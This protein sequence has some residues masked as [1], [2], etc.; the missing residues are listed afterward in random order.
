MRAVV[1]V[2]VGVVLVVVVES[3]MVVVGAVR[4]LV[5]LEGVEEARSVV[6]RRCLLSLLLE[7]DWVV[8][9]LNLCPVLDEV[10]VVELF[11]VVL[12]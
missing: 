10:V 12:V 2:L 7:G 6:G 5:D 9:T 8:R 4:R 3:K 1:V 11:G